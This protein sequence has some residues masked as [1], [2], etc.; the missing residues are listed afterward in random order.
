MA[1]AAGASYGLSIAITEKDGT[2]HSLTAGD[3]SF[4]RPGVKAYHIKQ[5][6]L[7]PDGA[8]LVFIVQKEEQDTQ[9]S[10]IRYMVE[11]VHS[12]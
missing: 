3:P 4:R 1:A 10:N 9:G 5:I 2:T 11:T 7:A 8:S 12:K 6:I